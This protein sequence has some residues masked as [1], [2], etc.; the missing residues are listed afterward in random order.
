M[1]PFIQQ[2]EKLRKRYG[3]DVAQVA[4]EYTLRKPRENASAYLAK[5]GSIFRHYNDGRGRSNARNFAIDET[6]FECDV[7]DL[8]VALEDDGIRPSYKSLASIPLYHIT[9]EQ[10]VIARDEL[11]SL[12]AK[13]VM[14][15]YHGEYVPEQSPPTC[16]RG[17]P[18]RIYAAFPERTDGRICKECRLCRAERQRLKRERKR[19]GGVS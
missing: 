14:S 18:Y 7:N 11:R 8:L 15:V 13:L 10:E 17:H 2:W 12:P 16:K 19:N 6:L 5:I 4:A 3:D 9:P 1:E